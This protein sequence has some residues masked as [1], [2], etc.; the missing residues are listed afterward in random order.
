V[1]EALSWRPHILSVFPLQTNLREKILTLQH[2][3]D[4]YKEVKDFIGQNTMM[5]PRFEGLT[6]DDNVLLRFKNRIYVPPNDKLRSLFLN[7][8]HRAVGSCCH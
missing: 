1:A 8:A 2:D 6:F 5:V 4:R 7:E 3:D